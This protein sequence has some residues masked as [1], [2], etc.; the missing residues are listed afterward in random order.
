MSNAIQ[1]NRR[2]FV[3][4]ALATAGALAVS[5]SKAGLFDGGETKP[6]YPVT[7]SGLLFGRG[8]GNLEPIYWLDN[9]RAMFG[10][11][12]H[13]PSR[14]TSDNKPSTSPF[15]IYI[16]N[17]KDNTYTRYANLLDAPRRFRYD[18][19]NIAYTLESD[20]HGNL[21]MMIGKMGEEKRATLKGGSGIRTELEPSMGP[22]MRFRHEGGET[23]VIYALL[24][25]HGHIF[26]GRGDVLRPGNPEDQIQLFRADQRQP[27]T[28]P[29]LVKE[30]YSGAVLSFS[31]YLNK[32]VLLPSMSRSQ[33]S[34][35]GSH[36]K[37]DEPTP[38]YLIS[39][40][41][42]VEN[43]EVPSGLWR[44]QA[45]FPTREGLFW[46]SNN[47]R[48]N[49]RDAGGWLLKDGKVTKLFDQLVDGAGVSP[50]G[51][52]IVYASNDFNPKTTEYL[53]AINL[54]KPMNKN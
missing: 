20:P 3:R 21:T 45:V 40:E 48:R 46:V 53:Q 8:V 49:S 16:W 37:T 39:P 50:D 13:L 6:P 35:S 11:Y 19:G 18:H 7:S 54:C 51:C 32:Y 42:K 23:S 43:V 27:I 5:D 31:P 14:E 1:P 36:W 15:G 12:A 41:G 2:A 10:A 9:D 4:A 22:G 38:I 29:I 17:V 26:V 34:H 28:L 33:D 25:E 24:S 52:T 47:T 30:M 44:P